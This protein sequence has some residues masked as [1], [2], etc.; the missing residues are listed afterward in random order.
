MKQLTAYL[1]V[2]MASR[3]RKR[4][5]GPKLMTS[6]SND[7]DSALLLSNLPLLWLHSIASPRKAAGAASRAKHSCQQLATWVGVNIADK[8]HLFHREASK[9]CN[10][11][12]NLLQTS[13]LMLGLYDSR[14][15]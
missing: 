12:R 5:L 10:L 14:F 11:D 1:M 2:R 6:S 8:G 7:D 3:V 4:M 9:S 13:I 15:C